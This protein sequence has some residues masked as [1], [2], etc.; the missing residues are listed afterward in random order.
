MDIG[1]VADIQYKGYWYFAI[2]KVKI[3]EFKWLYQQ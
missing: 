1:G 2:I 3:K